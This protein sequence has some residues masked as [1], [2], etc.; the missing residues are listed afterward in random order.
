[1]HWKLLHQFEERK[2]VFLARSVPEAC[3]GWEKSL[4]ENFPEMDRL[5]KLA[6]ILIIW[7]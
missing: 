4:H 7:T 1:M 2:G 5:Q 6:A 3:F